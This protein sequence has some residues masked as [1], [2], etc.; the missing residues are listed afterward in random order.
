ME[1][2][3]KQ[4]IETLCQPGKGILAADESTGTIGKRF[5]LIDVE[6]IEEN[7]RKYRDFL[8]TS[9][10]FGEY[11]SGVILFEEQVFQKSEDGRTFPE[12]IVAAGAVPGWKSD[13]GLDPIPGYGSDLIVKGLDTLDGRCKRV[14]EAGARFTKFRSMFNVAK[15]LNKPSRYSIEMNAIHQARNAKISQVNGLVPIV[16]P[17]VIV[18]EGEDIDIEYAFKVTRDI[19]VETFKQLSL[20][21]VD[22][23]YMILKPNMIY[24]KAVLAEG[25]N[26]MIAEYTMRLFRE[27]VPVSVPGIF[28]LS[29]GQDEI[30]STLNLDL[31]NKIKK[32]EGSAPW[33][34]SFS[35][36]RALQASALS[37]W[38][39]LDENRES[40]QGVF[41]KRARLNGLA[42]KGE[43]EG[44][45]N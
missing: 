24:T 22:L 23:R 1:T 8:F 15:S 37:A 18:G 38:R 21:Q 6:N 16:E 20:A 27:A 44:E 2:V 3:L 28:F 42:S 41:I 40:M 31:V 34:I 39:G 43:Y 10:N 30:S 7:R 17:E 29:G 45:E 12:V 32:R 35:Y 19:L 14:F 36:G 25:L 11:I 9:P 5:D 33:Y 13:L 26:E 4:T